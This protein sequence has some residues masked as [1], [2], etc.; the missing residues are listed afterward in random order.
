MFDKLFDELTKCFLV[1]KLQNTERRIGYKLR[2]H[3]LPEQFIEGWVRWDM[4]KQF[5]RAGLDVEAGVNYWTTGKIARGICSR[6]DRDAS[7]YQSWVG[8]YVVRL[9]PGQS[10]EVKE[11]F[12]LAIVDQNGWLSSYGD[13][14]PTT[15]ID[16]CEFTAIDKIASGNFH[17]TLYEGACKTHSD[18]GSGK[19]SF[20]LLV[21]SI[22][23]A[24]L[25]N[26]S[27]PELALH[28]RMF[29]PPGCR[30]PYE[31]IKLHGYLAVFDVEENVKVVLYGNGALISKDDG[32]SDTFNA[33]GK[34]LLSAMRSCDIVPIPR[35]TRP[36]S[37][38]LA[39][40]K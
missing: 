10:W 30:R 40:S 20:T 38:L 6:F 15:T 19:K 36:N 4:T 16:G 37:P 1:P 34:A 39:V 13:P 33:L 17:G 14:H 26:I 35:N 7:T 31:P 2:F 22:A 25:F 18:V 8:G 27:N 9:S 23:V 29:I 12:R 11:H 21:H 3:C 32:D 5:N 24:S 28:G